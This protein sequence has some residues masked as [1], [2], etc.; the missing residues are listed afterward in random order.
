MHFRNLT[1]EHEL[2]VKEN[3]SREVNV[4]QIYPPYSVQRNREDNHME[5]DMLGSN[6]VKDTTKILREKIK[7]GVHN[8]SSCFS[9]QAIL[10]HRAL[11]SENKELRVK[12]R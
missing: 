9:S 6:D 10:W 4:F 5:Y 2:D 3:L 11:A 12:T 1:E 7:M 8:D